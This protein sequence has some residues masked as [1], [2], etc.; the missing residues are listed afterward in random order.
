MS[1]SRLVPFNPVDMSL[2][3]LN[4]KLRLAGG[5]NNRVLFSLF[6]FTSEDAAVKEIIND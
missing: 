4:N 2:N 3:W 6:W 1:F 5:F